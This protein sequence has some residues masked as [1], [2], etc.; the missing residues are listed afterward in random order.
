MNFIAPD[1]PDD[2]G[3]DGFTLLDFLIGAV[4]IAL[5]CGCVWWLTTLLFGP[6]IPAH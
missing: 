6:G 1:G 2:D 5:A 4:M 3:P